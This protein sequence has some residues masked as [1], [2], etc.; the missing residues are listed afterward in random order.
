MGGVC[1]PDCRDRKRNSELI[2]LLTC[3]KDISEHIARY[4]TSIINEVDLILCRAAIFRRPENIHSMTIYPGHRGKLG[5]GWT[6]G[7]SKKCRVPELL[8]KHG[9]SVNTRRRD[10]RAMD[11]EESAIIFRKTGV[12][13]L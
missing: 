7:A 4:S 10:E 13:I 1:G 2:P 5:L 8:S 3:K 9:T 12:F 6:R 11:K